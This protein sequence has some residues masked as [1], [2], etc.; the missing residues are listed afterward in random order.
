MFQHVRI[1]RGP[2]AELVLARPDARNAMTVAMGDEVA[3][4]VAELDRDPAV[5]VVLVRGEGKAFCAGGDLGFL[6]QRL[7][8][9]REGNTR[10]MG[11][12]YRRFLSIRDLRVPTIAVLH[13]AAM[14]AG[15]CF[16]LGCDLRLAARS[17]PLGL[18]FVRLGLHP[19]MGATYLLPQLVGPAIAADLLLTGRTIDGT[20]AARI[21]M[22]NEAL[23]D[24]ALMPRARELAGLIASAGPLAVTACKR[25]LGAAHGTLEQALDGEARAQAEDYA[26]R[27]LA[28]G[29]RAARERRTPSFEGK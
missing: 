17:A 21:G 25:S 24:D 2:I 7:S 16:A 20:E 4:A 19:G 18:N 11:L 13:G 15:L 27:D 22:V 5:R 8:D 3:A 6:E 28:E 29:V 14:G 1:E 12:F 23:D 26:T 10:E 9:T